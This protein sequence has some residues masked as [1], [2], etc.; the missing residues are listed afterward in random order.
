MALLSSPL[1]ERGEAVERDWSAL[2]L[3]R[4]GNPVDE[5]ADLSTRLAK[6]LLDRALGSLPRALPLQRAVARDV[7]NGFLHPPL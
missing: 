2:L 7:A 3:D 4:L 5:F 1:A 6:A